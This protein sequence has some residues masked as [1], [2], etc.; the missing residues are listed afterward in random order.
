M[1]KVNSEIV[2]EHLKEAMLP[3]RTKNEHYIPEHGVYGLTVEG[4]LWESDNKSR[5]IHI[6]YDNIRGN[7]ERNRYLDQLEKKEKMLEKKVEEKIRTEEELLSYKK[8]FRLNFDNYGYLESYKRNERSI[9]QCTDKLG[10]FILLTSEKMSASDALQIYRDRDSTEK[11]FRALKTGLEY[12]TYR[13]HSQQSLEGKTHVMFI[14]SIVR[15]RLFR[16]LKNTRGKDKKNFTVPAA[17]SELEKVIAIK[18]KYGKYIRRY[19]LTAKQKKILE[20]FG[21]DDK[22]L[23]KII[24]ELTQITIGAFLVT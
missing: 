10:F 4:K 17:I 9:K 2:E 22:Y 18:D 24:Q 20:P 1:I 11:I 6:F 5:Y 23:N 7:E 16:V 3:L 13:V 15:N 21:I 8:H 14:A 19:G 12:D